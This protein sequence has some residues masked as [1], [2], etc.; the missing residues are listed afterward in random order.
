MACEMIVIEAGF[1]GAWGNVLRYQVLYRG[2]PADGRHFRRRD[3]EA[4]LAARNVGLRVC[5]FR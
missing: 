3:G 2:S 4:E 5:I 1:V